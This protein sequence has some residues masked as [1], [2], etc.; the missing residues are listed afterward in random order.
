[1]EAGPHGQ[2]SNRRRK[3]WLAQ[4]WKQFDC[5]GRVPGARQAQISGR[6][7]EAA[8]SAGLSEDRGRLARF[9]HYLRAAPFRGR[10]TMNSVPSPSSLRTW[11]SP[12]WASTSRRAMVNPSPTPPVARDLDLSTR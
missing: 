12:P 8:E 6:G 9:H 4:S 7:T 2:Q 10:Q 1:M 11:M 3:T 5:T